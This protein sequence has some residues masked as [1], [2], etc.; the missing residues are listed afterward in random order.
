M[1]YKA[2][3]RSQFTYHAERYQSLIENTKLAQADRVA[4]YMLAI[5]WSD[6]VAGVGNEPLQPH[7]EPKYAT[8][9]S[10]RTRSMTVPSYVEMATAG[11]RT[12]RE[13]GE[14][15]TRSNITAQI[16]N[17]ETPGT[18]AH[19]LKNRQMRQLDIQ[20]ECIAAAYVLG[21]WYFAANK[22]VIIDSDVAT[23][24]AELGTPMTGYHVVWDPTPTMHAEMKIL[25]C[26][27][28]R[29][30]PLADVNMGV[31]KP[32]CLRCR[33][34]L[35]AQGVAYTSYHDSVIDADHWTAPF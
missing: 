3:N 31:S 16:T 4:S 10:T 33:Q 18:A 26:L 15:R 11:M 28:S 29:E 19:W 5:V 9:V 27:R 17:T 8:W 20:L 2:T 14:Y 1:P 30:I 23:I 35:E 6:G 13:R 12:K 34:V 24:L 22:L 21:T 7:G 25:K 32:C